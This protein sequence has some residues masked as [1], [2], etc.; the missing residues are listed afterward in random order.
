MAI[1]YHHHGNSYWQPSSSP[2]S[3][4]RVHPFHTLR[5][6]TLDV[7][8]THRMKHIFVDTR[9]KVV[10]SQ[11]TPSSPNRSL[12]Y[13]ASVALSNDC[14]SRC[15]VRHAMLCALPAVLSHAATA[16][17]TA[18]ATIS[19]ATAAADADINADTH[20]DADAD[21]DASLSAWWHGGMLAWRHVVET[22]GMSA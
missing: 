19:A 4:T 9:P 21:A 1:F 14:R 15:I 3:N 5:D 11:S 8:K 16:A 17:A 10:K 18:A 6:K 12:D 7:S 22:S 20:V 2:N 13:K